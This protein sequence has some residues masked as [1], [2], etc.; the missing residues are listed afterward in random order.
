MRMFCAF[1]GYSSKRL[2]STTCETGPH[3]KDSL[4]A[5]NG[6]MHHDCSANAYHIIELAGGVMWQIHAAVRA[7]GEVDVSAKVT[8]PVG[9]MNAYGCIRCKAHPSVHPDIPGW[10]CQEFTGSVCHNREC[11]CRRRIAG[12]HISCNTG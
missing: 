12:I 7:V 10:S 11:S 1:R 2:R 5:L 4:H 8:A 6:S 3:P 9:I